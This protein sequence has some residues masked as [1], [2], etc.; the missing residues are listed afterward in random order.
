MELKLWGQHP[1]QTASPLQ[2]TRRR[3]F[4]WTAAHIPGQTLSPLDLWWS[5]LQPKTSRHIEL[6]KHQFSI[7]LNSDVTALFANISVLIEREWFSAVSAY[8]FS[9]SWC[10]SKNSNCT[11]NPSEWLWGAQLGRIWEAAHCC[12]TGGMAE[13]AGLGMVLWHTPHCLGSRGHGVWGRVHA[14]LLYVAVLFVGQSLC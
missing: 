12:A 14:L 13:A 2:W 6:V 10:I 3:G 1:S 4:Y 8:S 7:L 5:W 11:F 9:W